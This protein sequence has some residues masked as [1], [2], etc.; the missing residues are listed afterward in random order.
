MFAP[1]KS[2]SSSILGHFGLKTRSPGQIKRKIVNTLFKAVI[3]NYCSKCLSWW[4]LGQVRNWVTWGKKLGH[5]TK[6][7]ENLV[8]T[9]AVT[10]LK[11]SPWIFLKIFVL[12]SS[13]SSLKLVTWG[14]KLGHLVKP[15]ENLVN[16]LAVTFLKQSSW[17]LLKMF[18]SM[19][20]R[21]RLQLGYIGSKTRSPGQISGKPC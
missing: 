7:K 4:V 10:F 15:A 8:N 2:R 9:L 13:R 1:M 3:M 20:S 5:K 6:S 16:T 12:M 17:I 18:V 11:H 14:Q 21:S 19:I